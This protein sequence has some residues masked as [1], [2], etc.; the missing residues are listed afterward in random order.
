MSYLHAS[1]FSRKG[2]FHAKVF[3]TQKVLHAKV[4]F[5]QRFFSRKVLFHAKVYFTQRPPAAAAR[6]S[7]ERRG[8]LRI[9]G[10]VHPVFLQ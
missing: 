5:T 6:R 8:M 3:F 9:R 2:F 4:F 7:K 1:F 10:F